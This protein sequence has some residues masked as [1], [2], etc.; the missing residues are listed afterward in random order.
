M[1]I[2]YAVVYYA[3]STHAF[4]ARIECRHCRLKPVDALNG[5]L[6]GMSSKSD[7]GQN[8]MAMTIQFVI[9]KDVMN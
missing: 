7:I 1:A 4:S 5:M 3:R 9:D 6:K 8:G 2:R